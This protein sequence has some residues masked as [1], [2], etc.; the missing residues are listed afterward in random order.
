MNPLI[1]YS[2]IEP[3]IFIYLLDAGSCSSVDCGIYGLLYS[4]LVEGEELVESIYGL[5]SVLRVQ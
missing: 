2:T 3:I 1:R 5:I 4:K